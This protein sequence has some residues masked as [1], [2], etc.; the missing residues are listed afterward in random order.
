MKNLLTLLL[1]SFTTLV[2]SQN[3]LDN[4][5]ITQGKASVKVIPKSI[6]FNISLETLDLDFKVSS[7]QA[8]SKISDLKKRLK[9]VG[10]PENLLKT[11]SFSVNEKTKYN[12]QTQKPDFI[13]FE[14]RVQLGILM[15]YEDFDVDKV[16]KILKD[17]FQA[18]FNMAYTLDENQSES[19]QEQ[20][21]QLAI[22]DA[23]YKAEFIAK[24][25][26]FKIGRVIKAQYGDSKVISDFINPNQE[27]LAN[28]VSYRMMGAS[29][30]KTSSRKSSI[31]D[32]LT[33]NEI[34]VYTHI[35][36]GWVIYYE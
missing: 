25:S 3:K 8:M 33:P 10:I 7:D 1:F 16:F 21:M 23:K 4:S 18:D 27:L 13:G 34:E 35:V 12:N 14:T 2:F 24:A 26:G 31:T 6:I 15:N 36:M 32:T 30:I 22:E 20:V 29:S 19:V 9:A 11:Q 17:D 5:I 28:D